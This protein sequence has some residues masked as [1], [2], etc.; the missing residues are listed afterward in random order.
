[1]SDRARIHRALDELLDALDEYRRAPVEEELVRLADVPLEAK[2]KAR[3]V[4]DGKLKAVHIGRETYTRR[5]YVAALVDVLEPVKRASAPVD[6]LADAVT[7]RALR[8][9]A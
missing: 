8:R 4:R 2:A 1:M 9:S 6:D 7:K 5:S 3:L